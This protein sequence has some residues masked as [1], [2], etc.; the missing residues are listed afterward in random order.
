MASAVPFGGFGQTVVVEAAGKP[1]PQPGE[2]LG[3][4]FSAVSPNYFAAMQMPLVKGRA[5]TSADGPG[6][7]P[8]AVIGQTLARQFW[9]NEDPIGQ[10]LK[11]GEQH[12][13]CTIVG[14]VN[15]VK[16]YNLRGRPGR[17]MYVSTRAISVAN[18]RICGANGQRFPGD[19]NGDPRLDMGGGPE[20]AGFFRRADGN[21]AGDTG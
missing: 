3:A 20:P 5:F 7:A 13:V 14:I 4:R 18:A 11:F 12:T 9:P 1:A 21:V 17:Q 16:M 2:I 6:D 8:V 15:D 19:G 10:K